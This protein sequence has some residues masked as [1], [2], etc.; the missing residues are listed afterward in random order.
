MNTLFCA[1]GLVLCVGVAGAEGV[2][3][4]ICQKPAPNILE[5]ALPN[6]TPTRLTYAE[7]EQYARA[8]QPPQA[9]VNQATIDPMPYDREGRVKYA[10]DPCLAL[11]ERIGYVPHD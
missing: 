9:A 1:L 6:I 11:M 4:P 10:P 2:R 8:T 7:W 3:E 5:C